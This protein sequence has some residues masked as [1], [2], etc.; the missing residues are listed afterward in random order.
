MREAVFAIT[1]NGTDYTFTSDDDGYLKN[2][3]FSDGIITVPFG[4]Y[5]L[6]ETTPPPGYNA[7]KSGINL[8][9]D[10]EGVHTTSYEVKEPTEDEE[11]YT[12]I[13]PNNP[14]VELPAAG[15]PG[16]TVLTIVGAALI[17]AAAGTLGMRKRR[18]SA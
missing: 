4:E 15:G 8:R 12:V 7:I 5:T 6:T 2:N 16:T 3:I 11:Y 10:S 1:I 18:L 17:A 9:V 14:G 13:I